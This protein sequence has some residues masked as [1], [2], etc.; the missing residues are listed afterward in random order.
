MSKWCDAVTLILTVP[1]TE[2]TNNNGFAELPTE[3][4]R[5]VFCN[6]KSVGYSE[7]YKSQQAGYKTELKL[8]LHTEDYSGEALIEF[9]GRRYKVLRTYESKAGDFTELTLSDLAE[10]SDADGAV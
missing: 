2:E 5:L 4:S 1:P 10:R 7:F 9:E 3:Q 8:D 6:K